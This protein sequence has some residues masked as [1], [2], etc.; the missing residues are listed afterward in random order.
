MNE[1]IL[2]SGEAISR[3]L[4]EK[5]KQNKILQSLT[6]RA[7]AHI[8]PSLCAIVKNLKLSE[9]CRNEFACRC[10]WLQMF[11]QSDLPSESAAVCGSV[12]DAPVGFEELKQP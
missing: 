1:K 12:P 10:R 2:L 5:T 4:I 7:T 9:H 8:G 3:S 6:R 11:V